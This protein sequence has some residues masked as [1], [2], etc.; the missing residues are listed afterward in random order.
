MREW[1]QLFT[2]GQPL[3]EQVEVR[4]FEKVV[5]KYCITANGFVVHKPMEEEHAMDHTVNFA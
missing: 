4:R 5:Y 2:Q 3:Y 1:T